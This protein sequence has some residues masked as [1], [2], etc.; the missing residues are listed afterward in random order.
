MT[1]DE[2]IEQL[3]GMAANEYPDDVAAVA[4]VRAEIEQLQADLATA[5]ET[6]RRLNRRFQEQESQ[7]RHYERATN[8]L[9][10]VG[11]VAQSH[12]QRITHWLDRLAD[13][14]REE[15]RKMRREHELSAA[16][17]ARLDLSQRL[18]TAHAEIESLRS[19][20]DSRPVGRGVC[21]WRY[22]FGIYDTAC[23]ECFELTNEDSLSQQP[24]MRWC[25]FCGSLI[26]EGAVKV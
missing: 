18:V 9:R 11:H 16:L 10:D 6:N 17:H 2:A 21:V 19:E 13:H 22:D 20:L 5:R 25:P 12:H 24:A 8:I 14:V 23:G 4:V 1:P 3:H 7:A 15:E 26:R